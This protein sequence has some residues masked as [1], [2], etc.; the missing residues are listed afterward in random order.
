MGQASLCWSVCWCCVYLPC[1]QFLVADD[2]F[3]ARVVFCSDW[4][5]FLSLKCHVWT[6]LIFTLGL[7]PYQRSN[8]E[9]QRLVEL[10]KT[11]ILNDCAVSTVSSYAGA[12]NRWIDWCKCYSFPPLQ[13]NPT[14]LPQVDMLNN[15][16]T[17]PLWYPSD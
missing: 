12:A 4:M 15:F 2:V 5:L 8:A 16:W 6:L 11:V 3:L 14:A 7:S 13:S 10:L 9:I 17:V 1:G